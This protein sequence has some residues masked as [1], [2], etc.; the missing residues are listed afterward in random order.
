MSC[1]P[2]KEAI[3]EALYEEEL[4]FWYEQGF[5]GEQCCIM[6]EETALERYNKGDYE[7]GDYDNEEC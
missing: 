5:I 4:Q 1:D 6:A 7:Q 3:L 2:N